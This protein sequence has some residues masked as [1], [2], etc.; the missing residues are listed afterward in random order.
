M[1]SVGAVVDLYQSAI[2][3]DGTVKA[4]CTTLN[5][6]VSWRKRDSYES[7]GHKTG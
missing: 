5:D 6:T 1:K 7:S 3:S 4:Q 2:I